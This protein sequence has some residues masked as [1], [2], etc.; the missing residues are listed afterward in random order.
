[1]P[2]TEV[3]KSNLEAHVEMEALRS[4]ARFQQIK[5]IEKRIDN[6]ANEIIKINE[7]IEKINKSINDE[8]ELRNNQIIKTGS[9]IIVLL[10]GLIGSLL[11]KV[12]LPLFFHKLG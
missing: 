6:L 12:V 1:M 9:A 7:Y 11:V 2:T 3:E 8:K 4:E 10:L 5:D